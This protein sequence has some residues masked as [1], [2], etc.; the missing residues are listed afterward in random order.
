MI[1]DH[2]FYDHF[3]QMWLL[4][5]NYRGIPKYK[6]HGHPLI[7]EK[8]SPGTVQASALCCATES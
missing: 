2:N 5:N 1:Y 8:C 7:F 4:I 3:T 6:P